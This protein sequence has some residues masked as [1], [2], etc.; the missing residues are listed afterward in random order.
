MD[1][2]YATV[3]IRESKETK[4]L[5]ITS[6][7][8]PEIT[9][10]ITEKWQSLLDISAKLANVP[11]VL[12]MKLNENNIEVFTKNQSNN[13]PY[14]QNEKAELLHGL[15]C[16][17]VVGKQERLL[18][19]DA[20]KDPA[21]S[22]NNPD[23]GLNMISY[24]GFP[25]NWPDGEVFGTV[26]LLDNKENAFNST[27]E[28]M[29]LTIKE[30]IE[31][32]LH[33]L[34]LKQELEEKK[35]QL[36][37]SNRTKTQFLSLISHDIRGSVG[38][39]QEFLK[40][41]VKDFASYSSDELHTMLKTLSRSISATY[42]TLQNLLSWSKR[43][44][45]KPNPYKSVCDLKE[46]L[47]N[48]L[49]YAEQG[50]LLKNHKIIKTY[51]DKEAIVLADSDMMEAVFR[52]LLTNAINYTPPGG[53]ISICIMDLNG[54]PAVEISDNG[55]GMDRKKL[56]TLFTHINNTPN[57][58]NEENKSAGIGLIMVKEFLDKN[59]ANIHYFSEP[60][61]GTRVRIIFNQ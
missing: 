50:I 2:R 6:F 14:R 52:N 51:V 12:I 23:I 8:K 34:I 15:Y 19:P 56:K 10:P 42:N 18:V 60:G 24:L 55:K 29:L 59:N 54:K 11:A 25:I 36:L 49:E 30:H 45:L 3:Y 5:S 28:K 33:A 38:T 26:C 48:A 47:D 7:K 9:D 41:I 35:E 37:Q 53:E 17:A 46:T 13:N 27:Y 40:L 20:R 43:D 16:E 57:T 32:D 44:L 58:E 4:K 31:T 21:W 61:K 1:R 22:D 39:A